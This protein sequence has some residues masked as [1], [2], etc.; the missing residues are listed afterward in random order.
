MPE[1]D[2]RKVVL[3][4]RDEETHSWIQRYAKAR[5]ISVTELT[6]KLWRKLRKEEGESA[7]LPSGDYTPP[8]LK[9]KL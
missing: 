4:V 7:T 3:N 1:N 2:F 8:F 5:N 9:K 6:E